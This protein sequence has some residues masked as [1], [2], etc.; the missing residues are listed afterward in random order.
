VEVD[1][2][3]FRMGGVASWGQLVAELSV[4]EVRRATQRERVVR[5]GR[6][7]YALPQVGMRR[8]RLGG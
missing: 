2:L 3:L 4:A 8:S 7:T 6:G 1:E 5:I